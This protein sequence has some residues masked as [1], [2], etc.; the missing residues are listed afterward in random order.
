MKPGA[1]V[2]AAAEYPAAM[3]SLPDLPP[4]VVARLLAEHAPPTRAPFVPELIL[5]FAPD[6]VPVW[7]AVDALVGAPSSGSPAPF[8]AVP[9]VGGQAMARTLLDHPEW[10][11]G[12]R[13]L[14]F[15]AGS[16]IG[17]LA[18][19]LAGAAEILATEID[20]VAVAVL[21]ANLALNGLA[22]RP[23]VRA[24]VVDVVGTDG[25]WDVVMAGDVCYERGPAGRIFPWLRGLAAT[26]P[27]LMADPDRGFLPTE[28]LEAVARYEVP[29]HRDIDGRATRVTTVYRV[30]GPSD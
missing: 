7:E 17:T 10:V 14:D 5:H 12:K 16:G 9:W 11:R 18:A 13:V 1:C 4:A 26:R 3:S 24:E 6:L 30:S 20:P 25:G 2:H 27:V 15:G 23:E 28:G 19:L 29:T 21:R 8:W 22:D